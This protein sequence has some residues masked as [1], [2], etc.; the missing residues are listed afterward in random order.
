MCRD[1]RILT[2]D[3]ESMCLSNC[4]RHVKAAWTTL[5]VHV[6][7]RLSLALYVKSTFLDPDPDPG[8]ERS[9]DW[10]MLIGDASHLTITAYRV[11]NSFMLS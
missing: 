6:R 10:T 5:D 2:V 8:P 7:D 11:A 4:L 1:D 3:I 9:S